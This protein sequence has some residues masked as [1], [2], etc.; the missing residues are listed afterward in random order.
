MSPRAVPVAAVRLPLAVSALPAVVER[1]TGL[2][3][4]DITMKT[5]HGHLI[6]STPGATCPCLTCDT[7]RVKKLVDLTGDFTFGLDG[8]MVLCP[9]CGNKRCPAATHH[10]YTCTGSNLP[11]QTPTR[12]PDA[13]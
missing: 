13:G 3:G 5:E 10:D 4:A 11:G 1:L 2:Y 12:R 6:F 7:E 8:G 9:A